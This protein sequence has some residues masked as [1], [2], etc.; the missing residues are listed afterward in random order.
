M[1][2]LKWEKAKW[3]LSL[4]SLS[5]PTNHHSHQILAEASLQ[6]YTEGGVHLGWTLQPTEPFA[7]LTTEKHRPSSMD[8]LI[9][10]NI[11][12]NSIGLIIKS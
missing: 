1:F 8:S 3:P 4:I 9:I 6:T 10:K 12:E 5:L 7:W 11:C 2:L